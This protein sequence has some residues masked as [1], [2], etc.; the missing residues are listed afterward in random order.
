MT[1]SEYNKARVALGRK[2]LDARESLSLTQ[3]EVAEKSSMHVN[4]YARMERGVA[5]PSFEKLQSV[6]R[7]L[8]LNSLDLF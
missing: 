1:N 2:L 8:K 6:M 3:S 5:N 4:Y 7:V